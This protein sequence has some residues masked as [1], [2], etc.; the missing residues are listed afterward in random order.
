MI[1]RKKMCNSLR[2]ALDKADPNLLEYP[3]IKRSRITYPMKFFIHSLKQAVTAYPEIISSEFKF[4]EETITKQLNV[5]IF[6][7]DK[8]RLRLTYDHKTDNVDA[9]CIGQE[10]DGT[11]KSF[12]VNDLV[13]EIA[14]YFPK[15]E[16]VVVKKKIIIR[17]KK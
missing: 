17:R 11:S 1:S 5:C 7:T 3:A 8:M 4:D 2:V 10:I 13:K 9:F 12:N 15:R 16:P 14:E 6:K